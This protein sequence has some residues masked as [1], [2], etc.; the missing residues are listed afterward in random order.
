[1]E[2][3]DNKSNLKRQIIVKKK[4]R[5]SKDHNTTFRQNLQK[6]IHQWYS[7]V[8][9]FSWGFIQK[10]FEECNVKSNSIILDPFSGS[11]S[12]LVE[13]SLA[14]IKSYGYDINP[15]MTFVS[16]TKTNFS[17]SEIFGGL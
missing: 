9:G 16:K 2:N 10:V 1:M 12:T 4:A 8:E 13:S 14:G 15:F 11:G 6:P 3:V 7:Y 5:F 17:I